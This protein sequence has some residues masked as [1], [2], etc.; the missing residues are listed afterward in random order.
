ME[1]KVFQEINNKVIVIVGT[2]GVGKSLMGVQLA[3]RLDGEVVS[4]DSMQVYKVILE[5]NFMNMVL[6][7]KVN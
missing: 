5:R 3:K 2:T 1:N 4:A 7:V 6:N